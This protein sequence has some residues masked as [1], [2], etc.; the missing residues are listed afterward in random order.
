M[1][2]KWK[3]KIDKKIVFAGILTFIGVFLFFNAIYRNVY[4]GTR[5]VWFFGLITNLFLGTGICRGIDWILY[6]VYGAWCPVDAGFYEEWKQKWNKLQKIFAMVFIALMFLAIWYFSLL[7]NG[8]FDS[9]YMAPNYSTGYVMIFTVV[10]QYGLC[11]WRFIRFMCKKL[12]P[13]MD[14]MQTVN[15]EQLKRA[16]ALEKESIIKMAKSEQ[17]KADL[18]SNV[19]H[20]L[21]TP[22]TSMV[23]YIEL[24]KKEKLDDTARDY[25]EVISDKAEKLKKMIESLFSITKAGS[26]N[27]ELKLEELD[28]NKLL[29]QLRADMEDKIAESDLSFMEVLT[30]ESTK[31]TTDNMYLYR[32]CQNLFENALK[33]SAKGTRVFVK[34]FIEVEGSKKDSQADAIAD[35]EHEQ[36]DGLVDVLKD[37]EDRHI[38]SAEAGGEK[39][40]KIDN[41]GNRKVC[42]EVT[43]TAGY[44]MEFDSSE[45]VER[46][47]RGDKSRTTEGNGLGLAIVSS[48]ASALGGTFDIKIDCDQFKAT[49]MLPCQGIKQ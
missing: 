48:Y 32:I 27:V 40:G 1:A 47:T 26:G 29:R 9:Y 39:Q 25:V 38:N 34:T 11:E 33:Y 43:N 5:E 18:I 22:L 30:P 3:N 23:G 45:I 12:N 15:E 41:T 46:F 2:I 21:K 6:Y 37:N 20:D 17:L 24:L 42:I 19:S 4:A 10:L 28:V 49:V 31:L 8:A 7:Q 13:L 14:Y 44:A 16:V 35:M 36:T